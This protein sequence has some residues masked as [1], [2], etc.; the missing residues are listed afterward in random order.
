MTLG[1]ECAIM[2]FVS[3]NFPFVRSIANER[4]ENCQKTVYQVMTHRNIEGSYYDFTILSQLLKSKLDY[5]VI[6]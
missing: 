1:T 3:D 2:S 4:T 5:L 6:K